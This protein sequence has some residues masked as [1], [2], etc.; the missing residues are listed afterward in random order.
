M[1]IETLPE[2]IPATFVSSTY[3]KMAAHGW[4]CNAS[5]KCQISRL[6]SLASNKPWR[7]KYYALHNQ[8]PPADKGCQEFEDFEDTSPFSSPLH[9]LHSRLVSFSSWPVLSLTCRVGSATSSCTR[10]LNYRE[11]D[12]TLSDNTSNSLNHERA[13]C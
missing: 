8:L 10:R 2:L 5:R 12:A 1:P 6:E 7:S 13:S 9:R 3:I 4:F 11:K